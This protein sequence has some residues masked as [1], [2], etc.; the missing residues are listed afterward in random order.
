MI[1]ISILVCLL[2][3][4]L[5]KMTYHFHDELHSLTTLIPNSYIKISWIYFLRTPNKTLKGLYL[6]S[7]LMYP[8]IIFFLNHV[9]YIFFLNNVILL[10]GRSS[11]QLLVLFVFALIYLICFV[12]FFPN[13]ISSTPLGKETASFVCF[14]HSDYSSAMTQF[15]QSQ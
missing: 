4:N 3:C 6:N 10:F 15:C 11:R 5:P 8:L 7:F 1:F 13:T 9:F 2:K 14:S 12:L